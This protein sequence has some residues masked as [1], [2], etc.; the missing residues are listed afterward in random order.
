MQL[1]LGDNFGVTI[2]SVSHS[3]APYVPS[4]RR[5]ARALS[6]SQD[7]GDAYVVAL[8][9]ALV[10]NPSI[11]PPELDPK[12]ALYRIFLKIWNSVDFNVFPDFNSDRSKAMRSLQTLTPMPR[13]A[14]LLLAVEGFDAEAI[15]QILETE[16]AGVADLIAAADDEIA[17]QLDPAGILIIEDEPI[18]AGHLEELVISLG[19]RVTGVARTHRDALK[20]ARK[21]K[22]DLILS[23]IQLADGSSGVEAVNE[24]LG[25]L[26]VPVIFI[27]GHPEMLL[28]GAKPEPTFL[29]SKP[30]NAETVK[31]VIGQAL[32]FEVRSRLKA[33]VLPAERGLKHI[34]PCRQDNRE[35]EPPGVFVPPVV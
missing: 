30:F 18:T 20:L 7:S 25:E 1:G 34:S 14:F 11:F 16:V 4:L 8:L 15:S 28:T 31:A 21:N 22:P 29:I 9:E 3:I 24:I 26:E 6:G 23:D 5:F 17:N 33:Q 27:T 19:H 32:F 13:Q 2:M 12:I 10:G 35:G